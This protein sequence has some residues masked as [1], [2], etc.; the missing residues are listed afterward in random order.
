MENIKIIGVG[1]GG[2]NVI[3]HLISMDLRGAEFIALDKD[4]LTLQMSKAEKKFLLG[5]SGCLQKILVALRGAEVVFMIAG[6]GGN[7]STNVSPTVAE[8][9][10]QIGA[11]TV[12]LVFMPFAFEGPRRKKNADMVIEK[13]K[14]N[15]DALIAIP[16]DNLLNLVDKQNS[17]VQAF[18]KVDEFLCKELERLIALSKDEF[19]EELSRGLAKNFAYLK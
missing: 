17:M 15:V 16:N 1:G 5:K 3:N 9:S 2:N 4:E 8:Y 12:A 14:H 19:H 7:T 11:L 18:V 6:L 13:L 10:R